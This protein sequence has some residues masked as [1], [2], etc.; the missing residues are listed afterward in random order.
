MDEVDVILRK[1]DGRLHRRVRT[2]RLGAD[3]HGVWL[4]TP[5]GTTVHYNY[6]P[7]RTGLT[8]HD[9]V[10]LIPH[11]QWWIAMFVA[12][13]ADREIYCDICLP[14]RWTAPD[15]VTVV[16][17]DLDLS[18]FRAGRVDLEDEDE[19]AVNAERYAYPHAVV[20][21]AT[22]AA[23]DLHRSLTG[24]AEPFGAAPL[25]WLDVLAGRS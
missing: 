6:G 21:G 15:E 22:T 3:R 19:F 7:R 17:L 10:R 24:R 11:D 2:T 8:R 25:P 1:Y 14:P 13:P 4:G 12:A 18:R 9:A 16:D 20:I 5:R 23:G